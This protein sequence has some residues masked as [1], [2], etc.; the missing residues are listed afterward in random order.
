MFGP[1]GLTDPLNLSGCANPDMILTLTPN[2]AVDQTIEMDDPLEPN[3]VQRARGAK[4]DSGGNG[5]NV[6]Q[7]LSA[8]GGETLATGVTGGFTGYYVEQNLEE[9]DVPTDFC[10]IESAPTRIN[11]TILAPAPAGLQTTRVAEESETERIQ[12][13]LKQPGPEVSEHMVDLLIETVGNHDPEILNV[14]GSLPPGMDAAD[15]DRIAAAGDWDTAVDIHGDI[16]PQLEETYEYCRPN[17]EVLET[18]TGVSIESIDDCEQAALRL[19]KMGFDRVIASMGSDG[20][21]MVTPK[22]TL[23]SSAIDV[24]VVDTVG[25]GDALFAGILWAHEQGWDDQQALRAGVAAAWKLVSVTGTS[26]R[27][28]SPEDQMDEVRVWELKR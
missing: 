15:I 11:T 20:A 24:D 18:A 7:F 4:F 3:T 9:F 8:L 2:P 10:T 21:V 27:T 26:I 23:Y 6:S 1:A 16:L 12:Y 22:K 19:Q 13:Q 14:G 17:R 5:I 25:A 28:L